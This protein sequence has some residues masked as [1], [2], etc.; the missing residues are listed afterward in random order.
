MLSAIAKQAANNVTSETGKSDTLSALAQEAANNVTSGGESSS[1]PYLVPSPSN[2][3]SVAVPASNAANVA[4]VPTPGIP[5]V[6][7]TQPA[8]TS[9]V[10]TAAQSYIPS[11]SPSV[12]YP[13]VPQVT[14]PGT[15]AAQTMVGTPLY[16]SA[17][18]GI[19]LPGQV[20]TMMIS[21]LTLK[22]FH[23]FIYK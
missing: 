20:R 8:A 19:V 13:V 12:G 3:A 2:G 1:S 11:P 6:T 21:T 10:A 15:P 16:Q 4:A 22:N 7:W 9:E 14:A 17:S 5:A 18:Q 23:S